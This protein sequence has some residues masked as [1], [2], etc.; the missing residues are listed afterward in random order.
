MYQM[1]SSDFTNKFVFFKYQNQPPEVFHKKGVPTKCTKFT[2]K[3][4]CES[5]SFNIFEDVRTAIFCCEFCEI[6][7]STFFTEHVQTTATEIWKAPIFPNLNIAASVF[8]PD[9]LES[10]ANEPVGFVNDND[11]NKVHQ[12]FS[13]FQISHLFDII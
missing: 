11:V 6:F 9:K 10:C 13:E 3:Q 12:R 7:K 8:I 1:L 4:L 2:G 5:I